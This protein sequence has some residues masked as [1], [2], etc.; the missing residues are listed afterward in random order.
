MFEKFYPHKYFGSSRHMGLVDFAL[1]VVIKIRSDAIQFIRSNSL[2]YTPST[3]YNSIYNIIVT[4]W[5]MCLHSNIA[6]PTLYY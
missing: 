5:G 3:Q 4:L 1:T 2:I 6:S